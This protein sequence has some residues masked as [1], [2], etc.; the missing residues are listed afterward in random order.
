M[1]AILTPQSL[2]AV[3][4]VLP[5]GGACVLLA[6]GRWLPRVAIDSIATAVALIGVFVAGV[7]VHV[8]AGDRVVTW[9]GGWQPRPGLTVGIVLVSDRAAAAL[10]LLIAALTVC[11]LLFGWRY[12]DD[13]QAHYHALMLLFL[14]GMTGFVLTGDL[15][16]M[17]VFF[18]LMGA[19]AYA[20]AALKIEE[21]E[22][23]QGGL[24]FAVINS[25]GGYLALVGTGLLYARTG[26]LGLPQLSVAL[27]GQPADILVRAA[28]VLIVT[29]W[30]VKAAAVPFHFWLA[31]AHAVAPSPV[32]VLFSGTMAPL[33]VY[34]VARLY[35]TAFRSV[36]PETA[37]HRTL[38]VIA[39][40]T[41]VVGASMC[42]TQRHIKRMLAYSTIAHIG[43][44][45]LGLAALNALGLA[46]S[47]VY[48]AGHAAIKGAL[49]L[50]AGALLNRYRSLDEVSLYGQA[51]DRRLNGALFVLG[52]LALAGLPPFGTGLGKSLVENAGGQAWLTALVIAV[53]AVTGGTVL[54]VALRVY[55]RIGPPPPERQT[56]GEVVTG[57]DE[58]PDERPPTKYTPLPIL[59][60]IALLL[61]GGLAL[62]SVPGLA[63]ASG[64][65][66]ALFADPGGYTAQALGAAAAP[67]AGGVPETTWEP[68]GLIL[69]F[70]SA[71]AACVVAFLAL[72]A[73]RLP[74]LV[75]RPSTAMGPVV[76][77]LHRLHSGHIGDYT[78]WLAFGSAVLAGLL[79]LG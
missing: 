8:T 26:Q 2:P 69:G 64:P 72:Y 27:A 54:R 31:D 48:L 76:A 24:T 20:L 6:I 61:A 33:G 43:L 57:R 44:F 73:S 51:C 56:A 25:L 68:T 18:E 79:I 34:A 53:S 50:L 15:F 21:P 47:G 4:I 29:G 58:Q 45:L 36:V 14:S 71:G 10:A 9:S 70:V 49:F 65:A 42:V 35:W 38:L 74:W 19:A 77:A 11:A 7:L 5:V 22:S 52:G 41:A 59:A 28:F 46:G 55:F 12:F 3:L 60:A 40:A 32:C 75:R 17:F 78:A 66:A 39:V 30:L 62:G 63:R 67:P 37:I 13:V 1:S 23:V 16:D